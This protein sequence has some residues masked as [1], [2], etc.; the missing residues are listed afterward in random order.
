[1][2]TEVSDTPGSA[3]VLKLS[4]LSTM[5]STNQPWP[6]LL[7]APCGEKNLNRILT[8][9]PEKAERSTSRVP[10]RTPV[11]LSNVNQLLLSVDT[12]TKPKSKLLSV[13]PPVR[14]DRVTPVGGS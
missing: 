7:D 1:M 4:E 2:P 9:C 13:R 5:S 11:R 14:K 8:L 6:G 3:I 12:S 10:V